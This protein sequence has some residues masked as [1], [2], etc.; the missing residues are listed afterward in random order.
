MVEAVMFWNEPNNKSHWAFEIDPEWRTFADMT[1]LAAEAV[2][3]ENPGVLRV[4]GG[5]SPIDPMFIANM[6]AQGVLERLHAVAVHGFPLDWNHWNINEWPDKLK[7]IQD[8]TNLP[9]WVS[10][11]GASSF[12]AEEVQEFGLRR[13]AQLL[14]GRA[15]RIHWYSLYDLPKA[16]PATTRHREEEGSS[17][18]RHFYM[19]LLREDG[20]PKLALAPFADYTPELGICQWFHFEDH[21]LDDAV[22]W[23]RRL[24]VTYLRTGLSWADSLRPHALD[25]F[26]RQMRALEGFEVTLTFCFTPESHG[27]MPHYTSPPQRIEEFAEFCVQMVRRYARRC[28]APPRPLKTEAMSA[29][30]NGQEAALGV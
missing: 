29:H 22:Q 5:I 28:S 6:Q 16:W 19:G 24:G 10:E 13:M 11:V 8:V 3:A 30:H 15:E 21:R 7:E 25:W 20:T 4:L 17:Y 27:V 26:D 12:G 14:C 2:A 23:L 18:Y 1:K 9:V